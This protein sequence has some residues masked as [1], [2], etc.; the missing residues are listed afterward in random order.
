MEEEQNNRQYIHTFCEVLDNFL[1]D[2]MWE[3][4]IQRELNRPQ[5]NN[6][7]EEIPPLVNDNAELALGILM[8]EA[9]Q[10]NKTLSAER[11]EGLQLVSEEYTS[12]VTEYEHSE[13]SVEAYE[14]TESDSDILARLTELKTQAELAAALTYQRHNEPVCNENM[15]T[16]EPISENSGHCTDMSS[17]ML[18]SEFY[19]KQMTSVDETKGRKRQRSHSSEGDR[20][21]KRWHSGVQH[22]I[23][24]GFP[25]DPIHWPSPPRPVT[26]LCSQYE[27]V[28]HEMVGQGVQ[29]RAMRREEEARGRKRDRSPSPG[30]QR[31]PRRRRNGSQSPPPRQRET[32]RQPAD[33]QPATPQ[34]PVH[35]PARRRLQPAAVRNPPQPPARPQQP[36][37]DPYI[38]QNM[39]MRMN[40]R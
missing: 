26:P 25:P 20:T 4:T 2:E 29:T 24:R 30:G 9:E 22:S 5:V 7:E 11:G 40:M 27:E 31:V 6:V 33:Q 15:Q 13:P 36:P 19:T 34:R 23:E 10:L 39:G 28:S 3:A 37:P 38:I 18:G 17:G 16:N 14:S 8:A 32:R 21:P 35:P 12:A 1:D